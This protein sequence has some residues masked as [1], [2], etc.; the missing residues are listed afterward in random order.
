[1][2]EKGRERLVS[3][4]Y[5]SFQGLLKFMDRGTHLQQEKKKT[6]ESSWHVHSCAHAQP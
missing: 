3:N 1:M 5:Q 2:G 4:L 6:L